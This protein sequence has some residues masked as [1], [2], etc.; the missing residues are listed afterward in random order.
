MEELRCKNCDAALDVSAAAGG[1]VKCFFCGSAFTLPKQNQSSEV[2]SYLRMGQNELN[3]CAFDRAYAAFSRAAELDPTEPEAHFGLALSEF[4]VQYVRDAVNHR[5]QPVCHESAVRSFSEC[6]HVQNALRCATN[7]QRKDYVEKANEIDSIRRKFTELAA[8]GLSYDCFICVKVTDEEGKYTKDGVDAGK[9]YHTLLQNGIRPFYSEYEMANRAGADYEAVIL[10]ALTVCKCMLIVCGN[11]EYLQTPWVKNEYTRYI[12]FLRG[13]EKK[14]DSITFVFRGTPIEK[15]PGIDGKIQGISLTEDVAAIDKIRSFVERFC[16][17]S[18]EQTKRSERKPGL[19]DKALDGVEKLR[20]FDWEH[21]NPIESVKSYVFRRPQ[22]ETTQ[23]R[24]ETKTPRAKPSTPFEVGSIIRFGRYRQDVASSEKSPIEWVVLEKR[25]GAALLI[26]R[27]ALDCLPYH[28]NFN[29][30]K[31][32]KSF[33]RKWLNRTFFKRAFTKEE[34]NRIRKCLVSNAEPR[35]EIYAKETKE[36][37]FLLSLSEY[38]EYGRDAKLKNVG[39]A[40]FYAER[41]AKRLGR[42]RRQIVDAARTNWWL[43]TMRRGKSSFDGTG[44]WRAYGYEAKINSGRGAL[45][46]TCP[47][48][49]VPVLWL[50]IGTTAD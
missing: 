38:C 25:S 41:R 5:L 32:K 10:Y 22:P 35:E 14:S 7:E 3:C 8:S 19:L 39:Q 29:L 43:R 49:V 1:V 30:K 16:K 13:G 4:K 21:F 11:E 6:K 18:R 42:K 28:K 50:K 31:W 44:E 46:V 23:A 17:N 2:L 37:V 27:Y 48:L 34:R 9:I 20:N 12:S 24:I 26:S 33:L 36:R 47:R 45:F 40:T 15:L